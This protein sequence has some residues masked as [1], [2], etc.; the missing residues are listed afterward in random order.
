MSDMEYN[1]GKLIQTGIDLEQM[2]EEDID[3]LY[4]QD[5]YII[6]GEA[7]K[8]EW[9]HRREDLYE[10]ARA[11]V[12]EDGTIDFETYHYNGGG[13]WTEVVESALNN[14]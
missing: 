8:V 4:E 12:N 10:I 6:D 7:Y 13:H 11:K 1:K 2:S 14:G 5:I 9:E 3:D